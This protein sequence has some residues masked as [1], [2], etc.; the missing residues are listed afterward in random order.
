MVW[1]QWW[2]YKV[3]LVSSD[4]DILGVYEL[5]DEEKNTVYYGEGMIKTRL[6]DHLNKKECPLARFYRREYLRTKEE[7]VARQKQLIEEYK[8]IHGKLPIYNERIG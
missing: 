2:A 4:P 5:G 1:S 6:M 7:C 3:E 8:R